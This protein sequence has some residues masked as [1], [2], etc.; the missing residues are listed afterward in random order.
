[1]N[2]QQIPCKDC[3]RINKLVNWRKDYNAY[4]CP[5]CNVK[6][7][8]RDPRKHEKCSACGKIAP[9]SRRD[10]SGQ[11]FCS[12]CYKRIFLARKKASFIPGKMTVLS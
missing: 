6:R 3:G 9:V 10:E 1:M 4:L 8:R 7:R 2:E 12:A 11:P 5:A